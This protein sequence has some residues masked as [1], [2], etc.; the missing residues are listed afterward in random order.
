MNY[1]DCNHDDTSI[2]DTKMIENILTDT[3]AI[4]HTRPMLD[5]DR[6]SPT[7]AVT[8]EVTRDE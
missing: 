4:G 6:A 1:L 8:F 7:L 3:T 5:S 2:R